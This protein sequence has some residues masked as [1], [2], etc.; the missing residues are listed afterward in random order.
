[1]FSVKIYD[2]FRQDSVEDFLLKKKKLDGDSIEK[3]VIRWGLIRVYPLFF[4]R[5]ELMSWGKTIQ[6]P[7]AQPILHRK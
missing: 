2:V 7:Q 1:M 5:I 6:Y 3:Q 4:E